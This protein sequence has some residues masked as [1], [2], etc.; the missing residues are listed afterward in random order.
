MA[1]DRTDGQL[2]PLFYRILTLWA[3]ALKACNRSS[4]VGIVFVIF[5][6]HFQPTFRIDIIYPLFNPNGPPTP[7]AVS[8]KRMRSGADLI[9]FDGFLILLNGFSKDDDY[10]YKTEHN[11]ILYFDLEEREWTE[12]IARGMFWTFSCVLASLYEGLSVRRS[13]ARFCRRRN[14]F[15]RRL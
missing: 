1:R 15:R 6:S 14:K 8:K 11:T 2:S 5:F 12:R 4:G 3:A 7:D 13:I 10:N 9:A